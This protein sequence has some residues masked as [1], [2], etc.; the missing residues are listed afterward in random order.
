F[1]GF[2][3]K[4]WVTLPDSATR[5]LAIDYK[6]NSIELYRNNN[7]YRTKGL[8]KSLEPVR[9]KLLTTLDDA[10][11]SVI[12]YLPAVGWNTSNKFMA[13]ILLHNGIL[14]KK[15]LEYQLMPMYGFY[16]N[17]LAGMGKISWNFFPEFSNI[18]ILSLSISGTQFAYDKETDFSKVKLEARAI[19][20][21]RDF[22]FYPRHILQASATRASDLE[23][24]PY[25][26]K[27]FRNYYNLG[28]TYQNPL[29]EKLTLVQYNFKANE[30]FGRT[31]LEVIYNLKPSFFKSPVRFRMFAGYMLYANRLIYA[32]NLDGRNGWNDFEY[33]GL[34]PGRFSNSGMLTA[35]FMP[36]EGGFSV[37]YGSYASNYLIS[38]GIEFR[39]LSKSIFKF[40]KV[41]GNI[42]QVSS[43]YTDGFYYEA[44]LKAGQPD[45]LEVYFP[46]IYDKGKLMFDYSELIRFNLNLKVLSPFNLM[47]RIPRI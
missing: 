3:G 1:P 19:F 27:E 47:E 28:Y 18:R 46:L 2:Y 26:S 39:L 20:H 4:K 42:A 29:K 21:N 12:Q 45:L 36:V 24:L 11:T 10:K 17:K 35:Q 37:P 25:L 23:Y 38:G 16:G 15:P 6:R 7:Y 9:F 40:V 13:G 34:F 32:F 5:L 31:S 44:G 33:E 22:R 30:D 41:Y 14:L 8:F 43:N